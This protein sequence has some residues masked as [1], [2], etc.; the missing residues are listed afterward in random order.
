M[1]ARYTA[2]TI[3]ALISLFILASIGGWLIYVLWALTH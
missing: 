3:A 1:I 2:Y